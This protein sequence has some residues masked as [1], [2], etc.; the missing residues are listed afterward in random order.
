MQL[1]EELQWVIM[2][3]LDVRS[4]CTARLVSKD[5]H[6]SAACHLKALWINC[7]SPQQPPT[8]RFT[9]LSALTHV[10]VSV[11]DDVQLHLLGNTRIAPF[12]TQVKVKRVTGVNTLA[13]LSLACPAGQLAPNDLAHLHLLPK[14]RSLSLEDGVSKVEL[15]PVRL[16]ELELWGGNTGSVS[17]LTRLLGLTSLTI[18][19]MGGTVSSLVSLTSLISLRSLRIMCEFRPPAMLSILTTLTALSLLIRGARTDGGSIF[20]DLVH[21]TRLSNLRV[22][23]S[24]VG[25]RL[26]DLAC[27]AHLTKLTGLRLDS[28]TLA[29]C[30][31]DSSVLVPLTGLVSLGICGG[32]LGISLLS[33]MNVKACKWL[34]LTASCGDIS[35]L[36]RA[37]TLTRLNLDWSRDA[38]GYLPELGPTLAR[39]SGLIDLALHLEDDADS[40][41]V[42]QLSTVLPALTNLTWLDYKGNFT[43]GDLEACAR[44]PSLRNLVLRGTRGVTAACVPALQA[45]SGLD[46]LTL[47]NTGIHKDELKPEVRAGFDVE[48]LSRGWARL[49]LRCVN[50]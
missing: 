20:S 40:L 36:E 10:E 21:L 14:L 27:F 2:G 17:P 49:K 42:F 25:L 8:T 12:I 33:K 43:V 32:P 16:E 4:L 30:V 24:T 1:P 29:E 26:E 45:M 28:S 41:G 9:Q 50:T 13:P 31:A 5:F 46:K 18:E 6:R 38:A 11:E 3:F 19:V 48:R 39:M 22:P 44:L 23:L 15:L 35:V 7:T 47:L 37:R 34:A